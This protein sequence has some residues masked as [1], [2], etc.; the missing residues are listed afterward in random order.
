[1]TQKYKQRLLLSLKE[2]NLFTIKKEKWL[3]YIRLDVLLVH[4]ELLETVFLLLTDVFLGK[5]EV[6]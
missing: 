3:D 1:M 4:K 6:L 2:D 5:Y